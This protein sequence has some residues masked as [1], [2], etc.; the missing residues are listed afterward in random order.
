METKTNPKDEKRFIVA[1]REGTHIKMTQYLERNHGINLKEFCEILILN[2]WQ[3]RQHRPA[4]EEVLSDYLELQTRNAAEEASPGNRTYKRVQELQQGLE[5][6]EKMIKA[7]Q[8]RV[9]ALKDKTGK[10]PGKLMAEVKSLD[11][12]RVKY[13][14]EIEDLQLGRVKTTLPG[15][16]EDAELAEQREEY[17]TLGGDY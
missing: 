4:I 10:W 2:F 6:L 1:C 11:D 13:E 16:G 7:K 9:R 5:D 15:T 3:R 12:L 17:I 14:R 8:H